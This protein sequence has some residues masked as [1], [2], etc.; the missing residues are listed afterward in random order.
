MARYEPSSHNNIYNDDMKSTERFDFPNML[1]LEWLKQFYLGWL[2]FI[3]NIF[4]V[5]EI[6]L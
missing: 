2:Y 1:F 6:S 3:F 5:L 4:I